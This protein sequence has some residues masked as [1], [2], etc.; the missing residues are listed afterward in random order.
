M[1]NLSS[2]TPKQNL[3]YH[4][5]KSHITIWY[6]CWTFHVQERTYFQG[7]HP[8]VFETNSKI[9]K[10]TCKFN[11]IFQ[12]YVLKIQ[13]LKNPSIFH[14]QQEKKPFITSHTNSKT[15]P[16]NTFKLLDIQ[17]TIPFPK[18]IAN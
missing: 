8:I 15:N 4:D 1:P 2:K 17:I 14:P 9:P 3:S 6:L 12:R 13:T 18:Q 16:P 11:S 10:T 7:I 5:P